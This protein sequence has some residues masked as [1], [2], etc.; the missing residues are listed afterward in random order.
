VGELSWTVM[1]QTGADAQ[2]AV[3]MMAADLLKPFVNDTGNT[4]FLLR[5]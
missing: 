5:A 4:R 3:V 1:G 2:R